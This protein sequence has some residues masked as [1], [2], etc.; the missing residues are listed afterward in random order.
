MAQGTAVLDQAQKLGHRVGTELRA[1]PNSGRVVLVAACL[2]GL[3][4]LALILSR[5]TAAPSYVT[6][7]SGLT[8]SDAASV[9]SALASA[10]IP[11]Q[12]SPDGSSILVPAAEVGQAKVAAGA[13][14]LPKGSTIN[15]SVFDQ[16]QFGLSNFQEQVMYVQALEG[17]L[18][19]TIEQL[20]EVQNARVEI[21]QP[22]SNVFLA[23]TPP[24]TAA[25]FL[26]LKP[27]ATMSAA[28]VQG[29]VNLVAHSVQGLSPKE[30][31][32]IDNLGN[33]LSGTG[34]ASAGTS[35]VGSV[36]NTLTAQEQFEQHL[37]QTLDNL[38]T[39]VLGP[40]NVVASV[41][42]SLN[43]NQV[44]STQTLFS[45]PSSKSPLYQS[46]NKLSES[47]S[48]TGTPSGVA[49]SSS[50]IPSYVLGQ[51]NQG[52][53]K[54]SKTQTQSTPALDKTVLTTEVAPG[55]V[56]RLTVA[57]V[58]NRHLSAAQA[59]LLT[60]TVAAAIGANSGRH[61]VVQV[62]GLPFN[63][64]LANTFGKQLARQ[65]AQAAM[66]NE[67][68]D[69]ILALAAFL[70]LFAVWRYLAARRDIAEEALNLQMRLASAA[71]APIPAPIGAER[72][73]TTSS[74]GADV[75]ELARKQ[76][77]DV[78]E[79]LRAWLKEDG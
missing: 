78:A 76:P 23:Q 34:A 73:P 10:K 1:L 70:L 17:E 6:A 33:V 24:A 60:A 40:G 64:S 18:D 47:F 39:P 75:A 59:K 5:A 63:Q 27:Y 22:T 77:A 35:S 44:T 21:V 29:V 79:V 51:S 16:S 19:Q 3:I 49:G 42:A 9:T 4:G 50:N 7:F 52:P 20:S 53:S 67:V 62:T 61:D 48:G 15:F 37:S 43:M 14:G 2:F 25:V 74:Y 11:Y 54:Y 66:A 68:R 26:Q 46:L 36:A 57:V 41:H 13:Q 56:K 28:Q 30:V 8:S 12:I 38:L 69:G 72:P 55:A 71:P 32:V 31:T 45:A 58:V 65:T